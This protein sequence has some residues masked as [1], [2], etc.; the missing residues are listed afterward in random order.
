MLLRVCVVILDCV[1]E[2]RRGGGKLSEGGMGPHLTYTMVD[3]SRPSNFFVASRVIMGY[4][5]E[6]PYSCILPSIIHLERTEEK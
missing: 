2:R 1:V 3:H 5:N 6:S 4:V